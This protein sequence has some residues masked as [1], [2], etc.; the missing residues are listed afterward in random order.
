LQKTVSE[1]KTLQEIVPI[2]SKCKKIRDDRGFWQQ[3]EMYVCMH[4]NASFSYAICPDC[5]WEYYNELEK[6]KEIS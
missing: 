2:C 6:L 1:I 3:V 5:T 4:S